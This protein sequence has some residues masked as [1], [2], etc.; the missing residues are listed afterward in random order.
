MRVDPN[1]FRPTE[2]DTLLGDASNAAKIL[3]WKPKITIDEM[4]DEMIEYDL[5][6]AKRLIKLREVGFNV[7]SKSPN[8]Y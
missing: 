7:S 4:I 2:T 1:Y 5:D 3:G 8:D 6:Q